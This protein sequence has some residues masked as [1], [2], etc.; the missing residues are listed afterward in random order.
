MGNARDTFIWDPGDGSDIVEGNNGVDTLDFRG[1]TTDE[2]MSLSPNGHRSLFLR[3]PGNIR[4]DM[5]DVER[6]ALTTLDGAD[7]LTVDDM[8]GTDFRRADVDLSGAAGGGDKGADIVTLNGTA[9][10]DRVR[11]RTSD[12]G[13][14]VNGLTTDVRLRGSE[15]IDHLE[16]NTLDGNDAVEVDGTVFA[17]ISPFVDLG[18]GQS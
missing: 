14:D 3:Q 1:A 16:V 7:T 11:V 8:A 12:A 6:L 18:P 2:V 13:V 9:E 15:T 5:D 17:L 4:M 10:A